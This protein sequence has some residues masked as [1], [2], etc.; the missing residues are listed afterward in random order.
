MI[1]KFRANNFNLVLDI[2]SGSVHIFDDFAYK[3]LDYWPDKNKIFANLTSY[4]KNEI[5]SAITEIKKLESDGVLF[6]KDFTPLDF[7][8]YKPV[9]KAMCL[10]VAHACNLKCRYCFAEEGN[11]H[12]KSSLM[13]L[14]IGQKAIDF[15]TSI[16]SLYIMPIYFYHFIKLQFII[17]FI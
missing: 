3:I 10:H 16:A 6:T 17:F 1:H 5:D 14:E 4:S 15:L 12:G 9:I 7:D 8:N 13:G 2:N 11:Y